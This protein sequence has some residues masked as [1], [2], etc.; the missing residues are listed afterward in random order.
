MMIMLEKMPD[1]PVNLASGTGISIKELAQLVCKHVNPEIKL[2]FDTSK[3]NGDLKRLMST[4]RAESYGFKP[5]ISMDEESKKPW[6]GTR[7]T[8]RSRKTGIMCLM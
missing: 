3:P 7:I 1:K 8:V 6:N 2:V 5:A 4:E